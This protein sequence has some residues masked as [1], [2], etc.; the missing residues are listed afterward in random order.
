MI[1][2]DA[3]LEALLFLKGEPMT[4][5][6]LAKFLNA[7]ENDIES[8][9][10]ILDK[11]LSDRGVRLIRKSGSVMLATSPESS[12]FTKKLIEEEINAELSK[13]ALEVLSIVVYRG[14]I[15]RV[16]IDYIRGVN[17]TFT[18]RNLLIRGLIERIINPRD[19]RSYLYRPS[20]Q[21]LQYLGIKDF[22]ELPEYGSFQKK[23]DN[24]I[25]QP[26]KENGQQDKNNNN[27][28]I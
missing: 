22:K 4:I 28:N 9:L 5:K 27:S 10:D 6:Q 18:I 15:T 7:K 21:L 19:S 26:R 25:N 2:L 17:C 24:F 12:E 1:N 11:K 8:A 16:Q 3:N 14:P 23:I 20:F 13:P